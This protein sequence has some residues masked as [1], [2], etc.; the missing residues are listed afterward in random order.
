M[1]LRLRT[2]SPIH[3]GSGNDIQPFDYVAQNG[4][5]SRVHFEAFAERL[6]DANPE[7][8]TQLS[9]WITGTAAKIAELE[10]Q[11][12]QNRERARDFVND[13]NMLRR[14]FTLT[15]FANA[16]LKM[17]DM[18]QALMT[19]DALARY[20]C[21]INTDRQYTLKE[22]IKT[23]DN[24][25]FI[26]GSSLKG[27]LRTALAFL[28]LTEADEPFKRELLNGVRGT[29]RRGLARY[30]DEARQLRTRRD[31]RELNRLE[32]KLGEEIEKTIFR[33][34]SIPRGKDVSYSEIHFDLM[35]SI[36]VSDTFN[37]AA[38]LS[39]LMTCPFLREKVRNNP[40]AAPK[41]TTQTPILLESLLP[42]SAFSLRIDADLGF[43]KLAR[44]AK[45]EWIGLD[46]RFERLFGFSR[47]S[48]AQT[49]PATASR[50][51]I[52]R[53]LDACAKFSAAIAAEEMRW[54]GQFGPQDTGR[55]ADF[56]RNLNALNGE[57]P[58]RLGWGSH[59]MATTILLALRN[60]PVLGDTM[61]DLVRAFEVDLIW[62]MKGKAGDPKTRTVRLDTFPRSRRMAAFGRSATAPFGWVAL[63][64]P[65]VPA[66]ESLLDVEALT[67]LF[68]QERPAG[69]G[70]SPQR[71]DATVRETPRQAQQA[72]RA[73]QEA[74]RG[75]KPTQTQPR[76]SGVRE[77][78]KISA[79]V[80]SNDGRTVV[81]RLLEN[82]NEEVSFQQPAYRFQTGDR[83]KVKVQRVDNSGRVTR[84]VPA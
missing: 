72:K 45:D 83:V 80:V 4:A 81:V 19:D 40:G 76:T 61:T 31:Y 54:A 17:P 77:N 24:G 23:A 60:D 82:Q 62:S 13:L 51:V 29:D 38:Q 8:L 9:E 37:P 66:G 22:Q 78:A 32:A 36:Q 25:L 33:C 75:L 6:F 53:I 55:I 15:H 21:P 52:D 46:A 70:R 49:D 14:N 18:A 79:E 27:A 57:T 65:A 63:S 74:M 39:V 1:E 64:D 71:P 50:R 41:L 12:R 42:N 5:F 73:M 35:R 30:P 10:E 48:L 67:R 58:I 44:E 56:Y 34:G 59:F 84:V 7:A 3:I 2:L 28:V 69:T 47:T 43:L 68:R 26:P 16:V 11:R 20:R